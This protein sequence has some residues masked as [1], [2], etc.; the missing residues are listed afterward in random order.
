MVKNKVLMKTC[1]KC[2]AVLMVF[3]LLLTFSGCQ[4]IYTLE[5]LHPYYNEISEAWVNG[6]YPGVVA[7]GIR[8]IEVGSEIGMVIG[9]DINIKN[10][11]AQQTAKNLR[12]KYGDVVNIEIGDFTA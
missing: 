2:V 5:E 3:I 12:E 9:I 8:P 6:E 7:F 4:K 11:Y 1:T 10:S